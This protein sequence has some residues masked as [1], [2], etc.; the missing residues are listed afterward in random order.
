MVTHSP[1]AFHLRMHG[2][3]QRLSGGTLEDLVRHAKKQ[4]E[5]FS[6]QVSILHILLHD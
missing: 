3:A 2:E 1:Y 4:G 6:E 5:R